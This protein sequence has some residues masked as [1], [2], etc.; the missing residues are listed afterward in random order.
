MRKVSRNNPI[1]TVIKKY[2]NKKSGKVT[3]SRKEIQRRFFGLDWKDQKKVM[4]AFLEAGVSDRNWAYSRLLDLWDASFEEKVQEL[5]EAYHEEKC[6]WVIIRHFP[7]EYLQKH[8]DQFNEGRDYYFICRRLAEDSGFVIDK[9]KLSKTDYLM[10]L[11]HADSHIA[12]EEATDTLYEIV[13]DIAFH[14]CPSMELSRDYMPQRREVMTAS[15][16]ANVS[17]ALYYIEK[18]GNDDVVTAFRTWENNVQGIVRDSEEYKALNS[19]S[20][21][22]YDYKDELATIVQNHLYYALPEKYKTMTD[23]EYAKRSEMNEE[24][25]WMNRSEAL[26]AEMSQIA[27]S[28][29]ETKDNFPF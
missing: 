18:M 5:W 20:I 16:F 1:A 2:M 9:Y 26:V 27:T 13:K 29:D 4:A 24:S 28:T 8:I 23:E 6:A 3:D 25:A 15:D 7:K 10:A 11:S 22:D 19:K 14:W 17:I 21:S 12:D